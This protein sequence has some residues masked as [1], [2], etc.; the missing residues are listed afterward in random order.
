MW[1]W[2]SVSSFL[3][4]GA[5][6]LNKASTVFCPAAQGQISFLSPSLPLTLPPSLLCPI[7]L[8][9][10]HLLQPQGPKWEEIKWANDSKICFF[11][12]PCLFGNF[13]FFIEIDHG[14]GREWLSFWLCW[15]KNK[16]KQKRVKRVLANIF[17][18]DCSRWLMESPRCKMWPCNFPNKVICHHP[19][20]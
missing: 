7:T 18:A 10:S 17:H 12:A 6:T 8:S 20:D 19:M 11:S 15:Y 4:D 9:L 1:A 2:R 3:N 13:L 14:V 5:E 16:T